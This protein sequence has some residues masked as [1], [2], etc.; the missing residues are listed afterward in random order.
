[1][2]SSFSEQKTQ[3]D[4]KAEVPKALLERRRAIISEL[5][6]TVPK[7]KKLE[8]EQ[9]QCVLRLKELDVEL[10][11]LLEVEDLP[12]FESELL[13]NRRETFENRLDQLRA[14]ISTLKVSLWTEDFISDV[15]FFCFKATHG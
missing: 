3:S 10:P 13:R 7:L 2:C 8:E 15:C 1:M 12:E 5:S 6:K 11:K 4:L 14:L 9:K